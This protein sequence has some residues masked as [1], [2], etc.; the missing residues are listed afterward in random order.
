MVYWRRNQLWEPAKKSRIRSGRLA[1]ALLVTVIAHGLDL[2]FLSAS[3][4]P[5]LASL[6]S[7]SLRFMPAIKLC[8][9]GNH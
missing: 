7:W 8:D 5:R 1:L 9:L 2:C 6:T 3:R 4:F